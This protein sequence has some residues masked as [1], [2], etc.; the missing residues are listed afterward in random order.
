ML[1][2]KNGAEWPD[3]LQGCSFCFFLELV[4]MV[5]DHAA[6]AR[7]ILVSTVQLRG[8]LCPKLIVKVVLLATVKLPLRR[9]TDRS[10]QRRT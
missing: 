3:P 7:N 5:V 4:A 10:I 6:E 2:L 8:V 9:A 1:P